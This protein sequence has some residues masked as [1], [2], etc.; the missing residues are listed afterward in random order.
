MPRPTCGCC[1]RR[2]QAA[3]PEDRPQPCRVPSAPHWCTDD[4]CEQ[5]S[6]TSGDVRRRWP[7][8]DLGD[9][10]DTGTG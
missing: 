2:L 1:A 6:P 5:L 7:T 10:A 3:R 9:T 8:Y 4:N